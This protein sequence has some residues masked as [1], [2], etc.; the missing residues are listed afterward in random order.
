GKIRSLQEI[1]TSSETGAVQTLPLIIKADTPGSVEALKGEITKFTHP[2]V[3]VKILHEGVGGVNESDVYLAAA[4]GAII[5][6]FHVVA[7]DRAEQ[8]AEREGVEIRPYGIIYE[9]TDDI[10]KVMEGLLP[11]ERVET[12]T[13]RALVLKVFEISRYG[14]IAGCRVLNGI[15]ERSNRIRVERDQRIVNEYPIAS[16]KRGKDDAKEVRDGLE[17]GIRLDGFDDIKEGDILRAFKVEE[18]KRTL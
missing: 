5:V 6:A 2:E 11:P 14:K 8:L 12:Q 16:L 18:I 9:I 7:E 15:I 10:K 13:G 3:E 1:L 4:S 17:C